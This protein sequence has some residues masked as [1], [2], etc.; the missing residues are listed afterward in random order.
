[1][2]PNFS[3]QESCCRYMGVFN[4]PKKIYSSCSLFGLEII[5]FRFPVIDSSPVFRTVDGWNPAP[6]GM[7]KTLLTMGESSSL[8]VQ[9]FSHQQY[10]LGASYEG[11]QP[12]SLA[13]RRLNSG[14]FFSF[15]EI[16]T[17]KRIFGIDVY[18]TQFSIIL[19]PNPGS[20]CGP[21]IYNYLPNPAEMQVQAPRLHV[22]SSKEPP[23]HWDCKEPSILA[24]RPGC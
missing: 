24:A 4:I 12:Q 17:K 13:S 11:N 10:Q 22:W 1:M 15:M 21:Y 3:F 14:R 5:V 23:E 2:T 6:P 20:F 8:V 18:K 19:C 9:D 16:S 7:V